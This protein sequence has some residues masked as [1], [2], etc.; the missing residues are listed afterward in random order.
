M[1]KNSSPKGAMSTMKS[2]SFGQN[3]GMNR[4]T[5]LYLEVEDTCI[6]VSEPLSR[7]DHPV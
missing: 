1:S 5:E 7:R 6:A 4:G 2:M 3:R